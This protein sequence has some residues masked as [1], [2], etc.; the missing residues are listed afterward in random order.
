MMMRKN[1]NRKVLLK[2]KKE[3]ILEIMQVQEEKKMV[4]DK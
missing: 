1:Q 3:K 2:I 4:V